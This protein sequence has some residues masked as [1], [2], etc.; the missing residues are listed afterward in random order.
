MLNL[1]FSTDLLR[2]CIR[3]HDIQRVVHE[4]GLVTPNYIIADEKTP[5]GWR[6]CSVTKED[7]EKMKNNEKDT[8]LEEIV[9][10]D[11]QKSGF[12]NFF[13]R[14]KNYFL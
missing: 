4:K 6:F 2:Y 5:S 14:I 1:L 9:M 8:E 13:S 3:K 10:M 12:T 7:I 11:E